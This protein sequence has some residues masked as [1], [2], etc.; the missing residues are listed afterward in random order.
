[1]ISAVDQSVFVMNA[2]GKAEWVF[3][4][5]LGRTGLFLA[6]VLLGAAYGL[7]FVAALISV[8]AVVTT[9]FFQ[10]LVN[11][12]TGFTFT[13]YFRSLT[14]ATFVSTLLCL[15]VWGVKGALFPLGWNLWIVLGLQIVAGVVT[16]G[17]AL[18]LWPG[19]DIRQ[20]VLWLQIR[21]PGLARSVMLSKALQRW[22]TWK[23]RLPKRV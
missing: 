3:W 10:Y 20:L 23:F 11:R 12:L 22:G 2:R 15:A 16:F 19:D 4:T 18:V 6:F 13:Q 1:M 9:L 21:V 17:L 7:N 5:T 8:H 14:P